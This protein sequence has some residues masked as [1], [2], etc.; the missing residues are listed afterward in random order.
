MVPGYWNG[1]PR[2]CWSPHPCGFLR[3]WH[4]VTPWV[5]KWGWSQVG[6]DGFTL[7]RTLRVWRVAREALRG[8]KMALEEQ[9]RELG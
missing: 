4:S 2:A 3:M 6:L 9:L 7:K 5:T 1:L 8:L